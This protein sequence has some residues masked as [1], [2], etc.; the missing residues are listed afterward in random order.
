[1]PSEN[2][3]KERYDELSVKRTFLEW[4]L[5]HLALLLDRYYVSQFGGGGG[6]DNMWL[7]AREEW[8]RSDVVWSMDGTIVGLGDRHGEKLL[9]DTTSGSCVDVDFAMLFEKEPKRREPE[10]I[11]FRVTQNMVA[12]MSFAGY[13][14]LFRS[15]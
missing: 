1:M 10:V 4:T 14:G 2:V 3:I 5:S 13:Q 9:I 15:I 6:H 8:T 7:A 11:S 12:V